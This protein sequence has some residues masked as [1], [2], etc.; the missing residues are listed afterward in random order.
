M[1]LITDVRNMAENCSN[2][3]AFTASL[4]ETFYIKLFY[5]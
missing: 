4:G 2:V 3:G 5:I 1:L